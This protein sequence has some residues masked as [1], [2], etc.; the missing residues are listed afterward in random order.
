[1]SAVIA[2]PATEAE[3][4]G[5]LI[6][7]LAAPRLPELSEVG[8]KARSVAELH[9]LGLPTAPGF[10]LTTAAHE[11]LFAAAGLLERVERLERWLPDDGARSELAE[12]CR[13][14]PMSP[15]LRASL[16][17]NIAAVFADG[18]LPSTTLAVRSSAVDED[19]HDASFAGLHDTLL[20]VTA[21]GA[22]EAVRECW[23]SLYSERAVAYRVQAGLPLR[24]LRMAVLV[25]RLVPAEA[26]AVVFTRGPIT[27][28]RHEITV[29]LARGLGEAIVGG[30]RT[31]DT[32]VLDR[33]SL[34]VR[35]HDP[36]DE[37]TA[38]FRA[39]SAGEAGEISSTGLAELAELC[40]LL[41]RQLGCALDIEAAYASD[42]WWLLQARPITA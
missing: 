27:R 21:T 5:P 1:M 8:G 40:L 39:G 32:I 28:N 20:G 42:R 35:R 7:P 6:H 25:Q 12:L 38:C 19:G 31:P 18:A 37:R 33:A 10:S 3:Q 17:G 26:S 9:R 22:A 41:E 11:H 13:S 14:T 29:A 4:A 16:R 36:G 34:A 30:R 2:S 15:L 24:G 23:A